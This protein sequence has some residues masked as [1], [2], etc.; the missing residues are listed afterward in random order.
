MVVG[1]A[2]RR[3]PAGMMVF[4]FADIKLAPDDRLDSGGLG[5]IHE[6][7]C[8]EDVAVVGHGD[9]RHAELFHPVDEL[10]N[11][12]GAVEHRV[13]GVQVQMDELGHGFRLHHSQILRFTAGWM[14]TADTEVTTDYHDPAGPL[15]HSVPAGFGIWKSTP[16]SSFNFI[17]AA[18]SISARGIF[19]MW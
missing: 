10:L 13:V 11:V 4:L 8:A 14:R 18:R 1:V 9:R 16:R 6:V 15:A 19:L 3:H 12:A 7:H 5:R 2:F 17:V